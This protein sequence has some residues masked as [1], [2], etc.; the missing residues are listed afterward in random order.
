MTIGLLATTFS[1]AMLPAAF[2]TSQGEGDPK[3]GW[4]QAAKDT[5]NAFSGKEFGEHASDPDSTNEDPHDTPRQGVGNLAEEL[6]GQKNPDELGEAVSGQ[7][8]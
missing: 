5:I 7:L 6:T 3:N 2:A 1:L 4:G 8:P